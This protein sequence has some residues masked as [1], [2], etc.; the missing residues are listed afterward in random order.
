MSGRGLS[1]YLLIIESRYVRMAYAWQRTFI[2][3]QFLD[4]NIWRWHMFC[5]GL[6]HNLQILGYRYLHVAYIWQRTVSSL[7]QPICSPGICL[8]ENSLY[9]YP[10]LEPGT[11]RWHMF[12]RG[13]FL[14]HS[15][16]S[17]AR[18]PYQMAWLGN[19]EYD[20][21]NSGNMETCQFNHT[22]M[23][24]EVIYCSADTN[25][26]LDHLIYL[27]CQRTASWYPIMMWHLM[28]TD[29]THFVISL[30]PSFLFMLKRTTLWQ[31]LKI[32]F[33]KCNKHSV[34]MIVTYTYSPERNIFISHH[35]CVLLVYFTSSLC[36]I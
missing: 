20:G 8:K 32:L 35:H 26:Q 33:V 6:F 14:H 4:P 31:K 24:S 25:V 16:W 7:T 10:T 13:L 12:G 29:F 36:Q 15:L 1:L 22:F 21:D 11:C 2:A 17:S 28:V 5:R 18:A 9:T 27:H 3:Y 34:L 23:T 30:G 19:R